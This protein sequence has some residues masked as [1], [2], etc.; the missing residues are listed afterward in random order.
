MNTE[1][2]CKVNSVIQQYDLRD[3]QHDTVDEGLV[4]RWHGNGPHQ[5]SGYRT[6]TAWFNKRVLRT[7]YESHGRSV[8]SHQLAA[9]YEALRGDDELL[10]QEVETDL[11]SSGIDVDTLTDSLLS[12]GSI[13]THLLDCLGGE[14]SAE[15]SASDWQRESIDIA[16]SVAEEKATE[17]LRALVNAG[18][19]DGGDGLSVDVDIQLR[20]DACPTVVP[21]DVAVDR[22]YVC[23]L[24]STSTAAVS[25]E[26][27]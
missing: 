7:V 3:P 18:E 13:R 5:E 2:G 17:A 21:F 9:D 26:H 14:K 20:C 10:K 4:A 1:C 16:R 19:L 24:H 27:R 11:R 6:L 8:L 22:G 15:E 25:S 12:Y 23:D